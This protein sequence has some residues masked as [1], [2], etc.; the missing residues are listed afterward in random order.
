MAMGS[1]QFV[2]GALLGNAVARRRARRRAERES[3]PQWRPDPLASVV[4]TT[5]RLWCEIATT[6][7]SR[8]LGFDYDATTQLTLQNWDLTLRFLQ[9]EPLRLSGM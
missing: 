7:G 3:A 5:R 4:I 9:S 6:T 1:P 8:W 2:A